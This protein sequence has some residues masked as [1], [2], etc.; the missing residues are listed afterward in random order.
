MKRNE[1]REELEMLDANGG[2]GFDGER[3][4]GENF[5]HFADNEDE[6]RGIFINSLDLTISKANR[7]MPSIRSKTAYNQRNA[8]MPEFS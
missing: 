1:R 8:K 2:G 6:F 3:E 4:R 5:E 7:K